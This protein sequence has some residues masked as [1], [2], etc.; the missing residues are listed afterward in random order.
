MQQF[1]QLV[2]FCKA[3]TLEPSENEGGLVAFL[4]SNWRYTKISLYNVY[5]LCENPC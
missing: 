1:N 5:I 4:Q 3:P 2:I